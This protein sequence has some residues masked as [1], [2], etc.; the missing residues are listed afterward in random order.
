MSRRRGIPIRITDDERAAVLEAVGR[1]DPPVVMFAPSSG[2]RAWAALN[3][4]LLSK[5]VAAE[6]FTHNAWHSAS[7]EER[8][9][10]MERAS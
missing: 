10:A 7:P 1:E 5:V 2:T 3:R 4:L 8:A 9:S 6:R